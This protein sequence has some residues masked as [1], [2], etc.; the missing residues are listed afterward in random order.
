MESV[1]IVQ[2]L[3]EAACFL[4]YSITLENDINP[5]VL[6]SS[7]GKMVEKTAFHIRK[8]VNDKTN[9]EFNLIQ[10]TPFNKLFL[11]YIHFT[12]EGSSTYMKGKYDSVKYLSPPNIFF[13]SIM[14]KKKKSKKSFKIQNVFFG[15]YRRNIFDI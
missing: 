1:I 8:P 4:L 15:F 12:A 10:C 6:S 9:P 2:I 7:L 5:S 14:Q 13:I 3:F 11:C